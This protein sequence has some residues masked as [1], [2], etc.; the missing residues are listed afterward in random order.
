MA[1]T[2]SAQNRDQVLASA[3]SELQSILPFDALQLLRHE[4]RRSEMREVFRTGYAADSAWALQHLFTEKYDLGFTNMLSPND[5]LP[6]AISSVR[7][8]YRDDFLESRIYRDHLRENGFLDGMS[9]ELFADKRYVGIAHF[10]AKSPLGFSEDARR[11]ASGVRGLLAALI[12]QSD[13]SSVTATPTTM[14]PASSTTHVEHAE[15][16]WYSFPARHS[17]APLGRSPVP[18]FLLSATFSQH[19]A[20]FRSGDLPGARHL[21]EHADGL[22]RLDLRRVNAEGET[23]VGIER[24]SASDHFQ[25]SLRELRVLSLLCA[26]HDDMSIA[27]RLHLSPRTVE[28]HVLNARRKLGAKNRVEAVVRAITTASYLPHPINCPLGE[29]LGLPS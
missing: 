29:V 3:V 10:S 2:I 6:P 26:G 27:T 17:S 11:A 22:V 12:L 5:G 25:L 4:P 21:W 14:A 9:M 28:S 20:Q 19:L 7:P 1:R 23:A 16:A 15:T 8:E 13:I 24:V 18:S